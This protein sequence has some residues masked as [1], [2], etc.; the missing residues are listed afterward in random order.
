MKGSASPMWADDDLELRVPVERAPEDEPEDMDR[1]LDVP[2]PARSREHLGHRRREAA[3]GCLDHRPGRLCRVKVDGDVQRLG[4]FQD[5]PEELV[6]EVAPPA[7]AV[8]ERSL[9][10]VLADHPLQFV[11]GLVGRCG[12]ERGEPRQVCRVLLDGIVEEVVRLAGESHCV[13]GLGLFR[14]W[15]GERKHLHVDPCG[16]HLGDSPLADVA[17]LREEP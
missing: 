14:A 4:V 6:V 3:V 11:G 9:E 5:R 7:V 10:T 2:A 8:D 12:R 16:V 15:R 1:G 17:E 13:G